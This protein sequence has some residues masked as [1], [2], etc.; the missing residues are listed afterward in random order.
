MNWSIHPG[1]LVSIQRYVL[2]EGNLHLGRTAAARPCLI[3]PNF[4]TIKLIPSSES[5]R[6]LFFI[7]PYRVCPLLALKSVP[8]WC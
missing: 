7:R 4:A 2:A 3:A 8:T 1:S 6:L 5:T